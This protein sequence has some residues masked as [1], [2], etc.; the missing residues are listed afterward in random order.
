M[1]LPKGTRVVLACTLKS[2]GGQS[3]NPE[4]EAFKKEGAVGTIL[5]SPREETHRYKI[6]FIDGIEV[7]AKR[8]Q[9][10]VLKHFQNVDFGENLDAIEKYD[11]FNKVVLECVVG[12]RAYGLDHANSDTDLR[13]IYQAPADLHWS[14][15]KVPP[16]LEKKESDECY[17]E[18]EKFLTLALKANPNV[19]EVLYTPLVNHASGVGQ[20]IL[21]KR[22]L[23]L[24]KLVYQTF[25]RYVLSQFKKLT[26][27]IERGDE[28][29]W[30]H[31]MHLI[32]L[33]LSG[34]TI[35]KEGFVPVRVEEHHKALCEI[36]DGERPWPDID[37]WRKSLHVE[38]DLAFEKTTLPDR[39]DYAA[40]DALLIAARR[41]LVVGKP[42]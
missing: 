21:E 15:M 4:K 39:P 28:I 22:E 33:L 18:L 8:G 17:W 9:I 42:S 30:K 40:I 19:L 32:R 31:A 11:L 7:M 36:R 38:M 13:G 16:Q 12:S 14:L 5:S 3:A 24:S 29:R 27:R 20:I 35:L 6:G 41:D 34:I 23:F 25:N 37:A 2:I 10:V 26:H 1:I